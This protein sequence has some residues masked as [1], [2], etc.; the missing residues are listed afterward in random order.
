MSLL[1]VRR[2]PI[3]VLGVLL[4][5]A[6]GS[7]SDLVGSGDEDA[8]EPM[9]TNTE[10]LSDNTVRM[11]LEPGK[12]TTA[13]FLFSAEAPAG[14]RI[15]VA[16]TDP[17]GWIPTADDE[18]LAEVETLLDGSFPKAA[19]LPVNKELTVRIGVEYQDASGKWQRMSLLHPV[20]DEQW[21][22]LMPAGEME[23]GMI[24]WAV[25]GDPMSGS[26]GVKLRLDE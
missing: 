5:T 20:S 6:C 3:L 12:Q 22:A 25:H 14:G 18:V 1:P 19:S 26:F 21:E 11:T 13:W 4:L 10:S 16:I 15:R 17:T 2:C 9:L 23:S 24:R 8:P 7:V